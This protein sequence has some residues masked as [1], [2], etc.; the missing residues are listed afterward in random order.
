[1]KRKM[2]RNRH[3]FIF[4]A[5]E[6]EKIDKYLRALELRF[7]GNDYD[8]RKFFFGDRIKDDRDHMKEDY[9]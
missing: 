4:N 1:M 8:K 9:Y 5:E 2:K 6:L 7:I 3:H